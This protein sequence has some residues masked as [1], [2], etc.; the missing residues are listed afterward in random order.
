[1]TIITK[2]ALI[3]RDLDILA[4][5][6]SKNVVHANISITTLDPVLGRAM[7]PRTSS[8]AGRLR[9]VRKL[10]DAGV[11]VRVLIAPI[12]PGLNDAEIPAILKAAR[13]AGAM[14]AGYILLRL[15]LTVAPVFLDWLDRTFPDRRPRVESRIRESR[16]GQLNDPRFGFRMA[17]TGEMAA[18]INQ[19]FSVFRR[20]LGLDRGL[21]PYDCSR[22]HPPSDLRGQ[23]RLF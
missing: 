18:Q 16:S 15:P 17:G 1:M 19:V 5:M 20:R 4:P 13:N 22:F 8:P 7:E 3:L 2:S 11:P 6:A 14:D 10:S 12:V 21:T 9:A 23:G